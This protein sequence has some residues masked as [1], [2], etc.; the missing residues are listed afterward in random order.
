MKKLEEEWEKIEAKPDKK[1]KVEGYYLLNQ[2]AKIEEL[3][4]NLKA[5]KIAKTDAEGKINSLENQLQTQ[6]DTLGATIESQGQEIEEQKTTVEKLKSEQEELSKEL[7]DLLNQ[8]NQFQQEIDTL[9]SQLSEKE[10]ETMTLIKENDELMS[11]VRDLQAHKEQL[12]TEKAQLAAGGQQVN[13]LQQ[14]IQ[15]KDRQIQAL[16]AQVQQFQTQP[17]P[18]PAPVPT[19]A[20]PI[21]RDELLSEKPQVPRPAFPTPARTQAPAEAEFSAKAVVKPGWSCPNCGSP[22]VVEESDRSKFLYMAA[23]RPIYGKKRRC[24]KCSNE[25]SV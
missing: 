21:S 24:L 15:Q 19:R 17:A 20:A 3:E 23:G 6:S 1:Y 7:N 11:E 5:E 9:K 4:R 16:N 12:E 22:R 13:E 18:A 14:I 8:N 25:W 10:K 2:K